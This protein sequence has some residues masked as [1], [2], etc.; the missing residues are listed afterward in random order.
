MRQKEKMVVMKKVMSMVM[1]TCDNT[2]EL[3][4]NLWELW[5]KNMKLVLDRN[6]I[7]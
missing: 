2:T 6:R 3:T 1:K 7:N 4:M 5:G